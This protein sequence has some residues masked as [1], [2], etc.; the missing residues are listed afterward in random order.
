MEHFI[1]R[2]FATCDN[3]SSCLA[4]STNHTIH[5]VAALNEISIPRVLSTRP[6][7]F[8]NQRLSRPFCC[9][10]SRAEAGQLVTLGRNQGDTRKRT[11]RNQGDTRKRTKPGT[12]GRPRGHPKK[13]EDQGREDQGDSR[14]LFWHCSARFSIDRS[15]RVEDIKNWAQ[16]ARLKR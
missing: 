9:Q 12:K 15:S 14:K 6:P 7:L 13:R 4:I 3:V 5:P 10:A 16:P 11:T 1:I 8:P 2:C